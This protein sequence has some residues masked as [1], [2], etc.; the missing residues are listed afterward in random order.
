MKKIITAIL[1]VAMFATMA[2]GVSAK[3]DNGSFGEVAK[4][5]GDDIEIDGEL[6]EAYTEFGLLATTDG[7]FPNGYTSETNAKGDVYFLHDGE[8]LYVFFDIDNNGRDVVV[9]TGELDGNCYQHHSIE[10]YFDWD[11]KGETGSRYVLL[12]YDYYIHESLCT[13][14]YTQELVDYAFTVDGDK[15]TIE[16]ALAFADGVE[17]GD[18][19]GICW[20]IVTRDDPATPKQQYISVPTLCDQV[21]VC[22][23]PETYPNITLSTEEVAFEAEVVE[24]APAADAGTAAPT[25]DVAVIVAAV[26]ALLSAGVIASKKKH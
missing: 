5:I 3:A 26:S 15:Y 22:N 9:P 21:A 25:A 4:Y 19:I 14:G 2:I 7:K 11:A 24:E 10:F 13:N 6:D 8:V 1:C 17:S 23:K 20:D 18:E 12:P 16:L